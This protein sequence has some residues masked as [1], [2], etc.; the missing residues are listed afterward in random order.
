MPQAMPAAAG[1]S[2]GLAPDPPPAPAENNTHEGIRRLGEASGRQIEIAERRRQNRSITSPM[3]LGADQRAAIHNHSGWM[4]A[5]MAMVPTTGGRQA[6]AE[7]LDCNAG[8][9]AD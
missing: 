3:T 1:E 4:D 6:L 2:L 8:A 5:L 7:L 9:S